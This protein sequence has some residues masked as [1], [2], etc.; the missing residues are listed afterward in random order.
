PVTGHVFMDRLLQD[1]K[2]AF[3]SLRRSPGLFLVASVSLALGI[4]VNVTIF[5]GV[6]ILLVRPLNYPNTDRMVQVWSDNPSRG[7]QRNSISLA[8][9]VDWRRESK[10]VTLAAYTGGDYNLADG[11]RPERVGGSRVSPDFFSLFGI[12]PALGRFFREEE[13]QP[14]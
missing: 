9:F 10:L 2:F 11:G 13:E 14:G 5:A 8:D 12:A 3:R 4:A 1:V 6:D 7:W